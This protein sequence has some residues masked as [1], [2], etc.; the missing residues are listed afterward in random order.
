MSRPQPYS[1]I[2]TEKEPGKR[3]MLSRRGEE[4]E[5]EFATVAGAYF[6][7]RSQAVEGEGQLVVLNDAGETGTLFL[8]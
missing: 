8:F 1:Y 2:L 4:W 7:A 5:K 3:Y 6:F